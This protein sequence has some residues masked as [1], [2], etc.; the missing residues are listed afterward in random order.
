LVGEA[1]HEDGLDLGTAGAGVMNRPSPG[2]TT[3]RPNPC[4]Q[5]FLQ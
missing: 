1:E 2:R 5:G 3:L 4:V